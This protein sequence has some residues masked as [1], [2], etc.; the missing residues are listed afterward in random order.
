MSSTY[1]GRLKVSPRQS[2]YHAL[3]TNRWCWQLGHTNLK[4]ILIIGYFE[5]GVEIFT[6][7]FRHLEKN[8]KKMNQVIWIK[9]KNTKNHTS[10]QKN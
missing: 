9:R 8:Y 2:I 1:I 5:F 4:K 3:K 10:W 6:E 7:F